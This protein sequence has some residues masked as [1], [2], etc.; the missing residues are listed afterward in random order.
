M[1]HQVLVI[2]KPDCVKRKL[3]T[4]LISAITAA[5]MIIKNIKITTLDDHLLKIIYKNVVQEHFYNDLASFMKSG[6]SMILLVS[7]IDAVQKMNLLKRELRK[8]YDEG[9]IELTDEDFRLWRANNHPNQ[10]ALNI[11]LIASNLLHVCD[12]EEESNQYAKM[13]F[14]T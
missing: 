1:E 11:K 4:R 3:E 12:S 13:I 5:D 8:I 10:T 2:L 9:W 6:P 7:G 14:K